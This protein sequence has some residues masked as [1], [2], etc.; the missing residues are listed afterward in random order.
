MKKKLIS[1]L[2]CLI[3]CLSPLTL[4]TSAEDTVLQT[5]TRLGID[6]E[7]SDEY[8]ADYTLV[9]QNSNLLFYADMDKGWFA[10]QNR[11]SGKIWYSNPCDAALD[12]ITTGS[13]RMDIFSDYV[14][15]YYDKT[16]VGETNKLTFNSHTNAVRQQT[17]DVEKNSNG[18]KVTYRFET[19]GLVVP[20][21][22]TL[23]EDSFEVK[24]CV[25]EIEET[26][27]YS[28]LSIRV[29]PNFGAGNS[30]TDGWMFIPDGSGAIASFGNGR[31]N[32]DGYEALVY[33]RE[34]A[35]EKIQIT[36]ADN[37][38]IRL[39][40]FGISDG[41]DAL[42]AAITKGEA[43]AAVRAEFVS[44]SFGYNN[45]SSR[46]ILRTVSTIDVNAQKAT[47]LSDCDYS[48]GDY[49]V[50]YYCLSGEDA[51]YVGMAKTYRNYLIEEKG[52]KKTVLSPALNLNIYGAIDVK[53][54]F[55]GIPYRKLKSLTSFSQ[56]KEIAS[57]L[58]ENGVEGLSVRYEG[59]TNYGLFNKK[60]PKN[61]KPLSV[62]GGEKG[63][64]A[65]NEY[66]TDV[67]AQFY[68]DVDFLRF[69]SSGNG[70]SKNKDSIK[71]TFGEVIEQYDYMLSVGAEK[72]DGNN[73]Y[74]LSADKLEAVVNAF[75]KK[76][77][78]LNT[79][80]ISYGTMGSHVYAD[81]NTSGGF[82]RTKLVN[83]F[84]NV[85]KSSS[86]Y[87]VAVEDGNM[88]AAVYADKV[89][90][91]P[92]SSSGNNL[93]DKDVPFYQ[94]VFHGYTALTTSPLNQTAN[95]RTLFLNAVETGAELLFD[96]IYEDAFLL[97]ETPYNNLYSTTFDLWKTKAV[98]YD[99]EYSS[100]LEKIYDKAI[101]DH[102][103]ISNG[104]YKTVYEDG[105]AVYVNYNSS[106]QV[107]SG[108][109]IG[110]MDFEVVSK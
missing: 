64:K 18:L 41:N 81:L 46:L 44:D 105:T 72:I 35:E 62:L 77:D 33:G 50:R 84:E 24:V 108:V 61:A 63:F 94:I 98:D 74:L 26:D 31:Y 39:P 30:E 100:L 19:Y 45:I 1:I 99:K 102:T 16:T 92:L 4:V 3:F 107:V 60:V 53:A 69:T 89:F 70:V 109:K 20:V 58:S 67:N 42:F 87:S 57:Y 2:I 86:D 7:T 83:A 65:L 51:S 28:I 47:K 90:G 27:I 104:V 82:N 66:L 17:V 36:A 93:F 73:Y 88:I 75:L 11:K 106:E 38:D 21:V 43:S 9:A 101:T 14:F 54:N 6:E 12:E 23:L 48:E 34:Y 15:E 79:K 29:L 95:D 49:V 110:G 97:N 10:L 78:S 91:V 56:A 55:L 32:I 96:G 103:E 40:V 59:W 71:N 76:F 25:D 8:I 13:S 85:F 37:Q 68:P 5:P 80:G 52:L 22:Y